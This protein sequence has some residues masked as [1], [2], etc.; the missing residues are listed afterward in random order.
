MVSLII[1]TSENKRMSK[2][3]IDTN[4]FVYGVDEDSQFYEKSRNL[5]E[6]TVHDL[7]TTTKN[8]SEFLSVMTSTV[9][10]CLPVDDALDVIQDF[11]KRVNILYSTPDSLSY[12]LTLLKKYKPTG[13]KVHDYEIA[14]IGLA[15][16]IQQIAT[17]NTKDFEGI[18]EIH[19]I[20]LHFS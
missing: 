4:I 2:V 18:E 3:L 8:I 11:Q 20:N 6:S 13:L 12:F 17:F 19:L 9:P 15:H 5:L 10:Y 7:Y 1:L 16:G 14:S